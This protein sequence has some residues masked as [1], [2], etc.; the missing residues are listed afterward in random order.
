MNATNTM[1]LWNPVSGD[2]FLKPW[3]E[4]D[5]QHKGY[6]SGLACYLQVRNGTFEQRKTFILIEAMH[7][8]VRDGIDP[9]KLHTVL[10][11]LEEYRDSCSDDMPGIAKW[12]RYE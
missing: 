5:H 3:P 7:L 1:L 10:L 2:V 8:I 4:R 11:G 9:Q 12:R 6:R